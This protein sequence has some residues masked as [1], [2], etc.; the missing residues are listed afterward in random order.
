MNSAPAVKRVGGTVQV[1]RPEV[2]TGE[3]GGSPHGP[4]IEGLAMQTTDV[5]KPLL[6]GCPPTY[7]GLSNPPAVVSALRQG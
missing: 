3:P 1:D 5:K 4:P 7:S 2:G 6:G